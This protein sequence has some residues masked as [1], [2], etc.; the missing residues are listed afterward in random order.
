MLEGPAGMLVTTARLPPLA[1]QLVA[2]LGLVGYAR[3]VLEMTQ[4]WC[5]PAATLHAA[6]A[7]PPPEAARPP[8]VAVIAKCVESGTLVTAKVPLYP[9]TPTPEVVTSWP[10]TKP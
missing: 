6:A 2:G 3:C 10:T 7:V 1:V 5:T 9:E 4:T 8:V